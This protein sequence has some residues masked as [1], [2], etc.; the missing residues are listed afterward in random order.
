MHGITIVDLNI[1]CKWRGNNS[2]GMLFDRADDRLVG[3]YRY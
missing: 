1:L 2:L 3:K